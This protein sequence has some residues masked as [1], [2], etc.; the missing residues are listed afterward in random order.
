LT[1]PPFLVSFLIVHLRRLLFDLVRPKRPLRDPVAARPGRLL[2]LGMIGTSVVDDTQ[3][4][5][6]RQSDRVTEIGYFDDGR[7]R[8]I[9][10]DGDAVDPEILTIM[11][12]TDYDTDH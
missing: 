9:W 1:G 12:E 2:P 3:Y 5:V 10:A 7:E 11:G 8:V 6:V 4:F